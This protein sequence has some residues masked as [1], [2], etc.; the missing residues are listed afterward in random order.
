MTSNQVKRLVALETTAAVAQRGTYSGLVR[1]CEAGVLKM[2][3]LSDQEL[4]WII[5]GKEEPMPADDEVDRRLQTYGG[6]Y[7]QQQ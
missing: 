3:D 4:W 1:L 7:V 2:P 6:A 5:V